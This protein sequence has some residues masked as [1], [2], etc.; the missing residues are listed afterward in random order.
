MTKWRFNLRNSRDLSLIGELTAASGKSL[1]LAHNAAGSSSWD[2]PMTRELSPYIQA[3]NTC[4]SAERYNW[5]ATQA[6]NLGG[7]PGQV[8]DWIWSGYVLPIKE[9]WTSDMMSVQCVGWMQ[10]L[11]VRMLRR[12]KAYTNSDDAPIIQDLLAEMNLTSA[13]QPDGTTYP[14]PVVAGSS[15]ATPTWMGWGGT[16]PNQGVGGATAY[17]PRASITLNKTKYQMVMPII[18]EITGFENG[19]DWKLDPKTRL[20]YI[21]RKRCTVRDQVLAFRWGPNNLGQFSRDIAADQKANYWLT[22][23]SQG[24]QSGMMDDT[25]DQSVNGLIE[26]L[27]QWTDQNNTGNL[28][29]N[30][31]AEILMRK[32]GRITYGITPF[33]YVGDI[34]RTPNSVPEPFVDYDPTC[35]ELKLSAYHPMRGK[36][37]LNTVRC[38]GCTVSIDEENN[39]QLSQLQVAP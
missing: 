27:S 17:V 25:A 24:V 34:N 37:S 21:Y 2:Y 28:I 22:T 7:T 19:C 30:S 15:P 3:Y 8:W 38:F 1:S 23:G 10:R 31:G 36:I 32:N 18:D 35:D 26:G 11:N 6:M 14:V 5:R 4:M 33:Y 16:L 13:P 20:L 9:D 39:E 12:D 29:L